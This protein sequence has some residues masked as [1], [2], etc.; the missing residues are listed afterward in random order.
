MFRLLYY[1]DE[2]I[3]MSGDFY[4]GPDFR[5]LGE[6]A[7]MTDRRASKKRWNEGKI[8]GQLGQELSKEELAE[9]DARFE[10]LSPV[11]TLIKRAEKCDPEAVKLL[12]EH[13]ERRGRNERAD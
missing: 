12:R 7:G 2:E 9:I 5:V 6:G 10:G 11:Q 8:P 3:A 13:H 1:I 4:L